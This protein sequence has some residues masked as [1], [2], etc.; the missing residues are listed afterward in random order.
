MTLQHQGGGGPKSVRP[1][2]TGLMGRNRLQLR[3]SFT[4]G[5]THFHINWLVAGCVLITVATLVRLGIWQ[6]NRAGEKLELQRELELQQLQNAVAI[7]TI[8]V[9]KLSMEDDLQNLHVSLEGEYLNDRTVLLLAQFFE[10]QI[11]YEVVTPIRLAS[12]G[13]LA[14][15]SRGWTSG[16]LPPD[17]PPSLRPVPGLQQITAQIHVPEENERVYSSRVE[18]GQWPVRVRSIEIDVLSELLGEPVFPFVVRLTEG[19]P[20]ALVRHWP[21]ANAD[22]NTNLSY[23]LQWFTF[24]VVVLLISIVASSDLL[25]RK[26]RGK[27]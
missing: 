16:I 19:Q 25:A 24:A 9:A 26:P 7:E 8:P 27:R 12:N 13:E 11:G 23:A 20:G 17:T 15:V 22:I 4:V 5:E 10:G 14:L 2:L 6:I 3:R 21:A 1:M 18:A